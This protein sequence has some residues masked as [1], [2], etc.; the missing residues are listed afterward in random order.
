MQSRPIGLP[1]DLPEQPEDR[2]AFTGLVGPALA[3]RYK[4]SGRD[5]Q[6]V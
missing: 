4:L 3:I 6:R 2:L 1:W 5:A